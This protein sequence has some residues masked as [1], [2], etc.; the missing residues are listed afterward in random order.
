MAVEV[1]QRCAT[2]ILDS[3]E[4]GGAV[5]SVETHGTF[6]MSAAQS[7][8]AARTEQSVESSSSP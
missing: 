4:R 5:R 2:T 8:H 1:L 6:S 7:I 3:A